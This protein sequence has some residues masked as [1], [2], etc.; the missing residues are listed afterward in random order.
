[1][2]LRRRHG[3]KGGEVSEDAASETPSYPLEGFETPRS[4][5]VEV[6]NKVLMVETENLEHE[7]F[8]SNNEVKVSSL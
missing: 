6:F 3:R 7:P 5:E 1:M 4:E 2:R 8:E